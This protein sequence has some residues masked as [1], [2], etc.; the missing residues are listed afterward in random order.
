MLLRK[1]SVFYRAYHSLSLIEFPWWCKYCLNLKMTQP[2]Q[3]KILLTYAC[4]TQDM[5]D[6]CEFDRSYVVIL[7]CAST[8]F[9][10]MELDCSEIT[11]LIWSI[12]LWGSFTLAFSTARTSSKVCALIILLT[13]LVM[14]IRG[15]SRCSFVETVRGYLFPSRSRMIFL[16]LNWTTRRANG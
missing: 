9:L 16:R 6:F 12:A 15:V 10:G 2:F 14:A 13:H 5:V 11:F 3:L 4:A 7:L 1:T 8:C